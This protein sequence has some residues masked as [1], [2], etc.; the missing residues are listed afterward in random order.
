MGRASRAFDPS[1]GTV[2]VSG[3]LSV[4]CVRLGAGVLEVAVR[5]VL[6]EAS[7][8]SALL[9]AMPAMREADACVVRLDLAVFGLGSL[10]TT[11]LAAYSGCST[12]CAL[13]VPPG[14]FVFWQAWAGLVAQEFSL[15]RVVF[16]TQNRS[17]GY[18]WAVDHAAAKRAKLPPSPPSPPRPGRAGRSAGRT[19][20]QPTA[21][22]T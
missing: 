14:A 19:T 15:V 22:Q 18:Q 4:D 1:W 3:Y 11:N 21:L 8:R 12:A 6:T 13:I 7:M 2:M 5:G 9:A 17:L 16:L 20:L 10:P